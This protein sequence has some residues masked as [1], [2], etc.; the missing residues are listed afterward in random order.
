M[1]KL[2]CIPGTLKLDISPCNQKEVKNCL[3]PELIKINPYVDEKCRPVKEILQFHSHDVLVPFYSYRNLL[4]VNPKE[5]NF[6]SKPGSARNIAI[7][8]Q[9]M[10]GEKESDSLPNIFGRS[11][12][13]DFTNEMF[14]AVNY[15]NK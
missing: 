4:F 9:L 14:T 6:S 13:P 3:T 1:K 11:S 10:C 2:K 5:V 7:K 15:H 8:V 12:C